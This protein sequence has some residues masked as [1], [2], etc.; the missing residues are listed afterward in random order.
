MNSVI[1]EAGIKT[2]GIAIEKTIQ[3]KFKDWFE[4]S[5]YDDP[6]SGISDYPPMLGLSF[7]FPS[8]FTD[9][10]SAD[11]KMH[12]NVDFGLLIKDNIE[13]LKGD[14]DGEVI[15]ARWAK[16]LRDLADEFDSKAKTAPGGKRSVMPVLPLDF[17]SKEGKASAEFAEAICTHPIDLTIIAPNG[18]RHCTQC[19]ADIKESEG[20]LL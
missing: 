5:V 7:L 13:S 8:D 19:G 12:V 10:G 2:L 3:E 16:Y 17:W 11:D 18:M 1:I 15:L 14:D 6:E 20:S 4:D 9:D